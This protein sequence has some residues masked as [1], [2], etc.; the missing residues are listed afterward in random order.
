MST[1][2]VTE[3]T[4][5][6]SKGVKQTIKQE[7]TEL[8]NKLK[9][10]Y[11]EFES[12]SYKD[13]KKKMISAFKLLKLLNSKIL[14]LMLKNPRKWN[15]TV[16]IIYDVA[17]LY[18]YEYFKGRYHDTIEHPFLKEFITECIRTCAKVYNYI[19]G[20][21]DTED[22]ES[23]IDLFDLD[24]LPPT[25]LPESELYDKVSFNLSIA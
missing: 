24:T 6:I 14:T 9:A 22:V 25:P 23:Y 17:N 3:I 11:A 12:I 5:N 7:E 4:F 21:K 1:Y 2:I 15:K 13:V 10:H 8:F 18:R 19:G 16:G 20:Y